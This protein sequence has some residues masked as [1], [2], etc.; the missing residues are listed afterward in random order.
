MAGACVPFPLLGSLT[1]ASIAFYY[2]RPG[3]KGS[4]SG[5]RSIFLDRSPR[6]S[7]LPPLP[8]STAAQSGGAGESK[9]SAAGASAPDAAQHTGENVVFYPNYDGNQ[10]YHAQCHAPHLPHLHAP[11]LHASHLKVVDLE[12]TVHDLAKKLEAYKHVSQG[13]K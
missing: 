1:N 8:S 5:A 9:T 6:S 13:G 10:F 3:I 12:R 7:P 2:R 4:P 11:D